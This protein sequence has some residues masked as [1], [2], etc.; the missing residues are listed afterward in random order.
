[1][2]FHDPRVLQRPLTL[3]EVQHNYQTSALLMHMQGF[4][5]LPRA[6]TPPAPVVSVLRDKPMSQ[7]KRLALVLLEQEVLQLDDDE[8]PDY[9][10]DLDVHAEWRTRVRTRM[11]TRIRELLRPVSV[12]GRR[13]RTALVK[14]RTMRY[15]PAFQ[16]T[17]ACAKH[18]TYKSRQCT[19]PTDAQRQLRKLC[20]I[21]TKQDRP[22]LLLFTFLTYQEYVRHYYDFFLP[23]TDGKNITE[24][25]NGDKRI[26]AGDKRPDERVD[27]WRTEVD[28]EG[29]EHDVLDETTM[30]TIVDGGKTRFLDA[31][32]TQG[33]DR[34][35]RL[36]TKTTRMAFCP[37]CAAVGSPW[38][39]VPLKRIGE[40]YQKPAGE[41]ATCP[42]CGGPEGTPVPRTEPITYTAKKRVRRNGEV[43]V[44]EEHFERING[45]WYYIRTHEQCSAILHHAIE[46]RW[47]KRVAPTPKAPPVRVFH[48]Q[49]EEVDGS[50]TFTLEGRRAWY[51]TLDLPTHQATQPPA[52]RTPRNLGKLIAFRT[53]VI[54]PWVPSSALRREL[55]AAGQQ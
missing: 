51:R 21:F 27:R 9:C 37:T 24:H 48:P 36:P 7:A 35:S 25:A 55:H 11:A 33:W 52:E 26:W 22:W 46:S 49:D 2:K 40:R 5:E 54:K 43:V 50:K 16:R 18:W 44:H 10:D 15:H 34:P 39:R 47:R 31:F 17:Q 4:T 53:E 20:A 28:D 38:F 14:L 23:T 12:R 3:E 13:M 32:D 30:V 19:C 6:Y 29:N 41:V 8:R 45:R 42:T 1:M